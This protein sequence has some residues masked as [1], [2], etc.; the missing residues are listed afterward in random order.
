[1]IT[2][3]RTLDI[4]YPKFVEPDEIILNTTMLVPP[5]KLGEQNLLE[6]DDGPEA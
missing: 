1:M 3:P 6:K 5:A 2:D 4:E